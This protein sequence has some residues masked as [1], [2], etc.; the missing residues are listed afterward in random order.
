[1][2]S[3]L[4]KGAPVEVTV[5]TL[6]DAATAAVRPAL[7]FFLIGAGCLLLIACTNVANL[8]L[9][10]GVSRWREV[11]IRTALGAG[12]RRLFQLFLV[13]SVLIA[14]FGGTLGTVAA[15]A[16]VKTIPV[17]APRDFPRWDE[18]RLDWD[19]V[20]FAFVIS[21]LAGVIAGVM[22]AFKGTRPELLT[23]S[24]EGTGASVGW[25]T[26]AARRL[27]LGAEA[28]LA[29]VL[30]VVGVL[31]ARS[32]VALLNVDPGYDA[33]NVLTARLYLPGFARQTQTETFIPA[34]LERARVIPGVVAAGAGGMAP[35]GVSTMATPLTVSLAGREA[36]TALSRVYVVTPGYTGVKAAAPCRPPAV[37]RG[38]VVSFT[39][40]CRQRDV[41]PHICSGRASR[42]GRTSG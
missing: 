38:Y 18:I 6:T 39:V 13:E 14:S 27:L 10:R 20:L 41:R 35:F 8:L 3:I 22:P 17:I 26:A 42:W 29:V 30:L 28:S 33:A 37:E 9:S 25:R 19:A 2:D 21:L 16:V 34:L 7:L 11:A 23:A 4:G 32:F 40:D 1:M 15:L 24:R 12:R 5:R 36:T 31:V